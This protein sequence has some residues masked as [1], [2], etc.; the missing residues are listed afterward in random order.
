MIA[1][2]PYAAPLAAGK[3]VDDDGCTE[4]TQGGQ[5]AV[6]VELVRPVAFTR[7]LGA[8]KPV[9]ASCTYMAAYW[10]IVRHSVR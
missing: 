9:P 7:P 1:F 10:T 8:G 6:T 3:A 4:L 5:T 2:T